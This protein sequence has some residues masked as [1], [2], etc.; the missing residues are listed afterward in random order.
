MSQS[1][2]KMPAGTNHTEL[3]C[4]GNYSEVERDFLFWVDGVALC[5]VSIPGLLLNVI[6]IITILTHKSMHNIFNYLLINLFIFDSTYILVTMLNQSFMKQFEIV[7]KLY[8]L[9]YPY[10]MHPLKHI[11][12]TASVFMTTT[13]AYERY[14][15]IVNPIE[16]RITMESKTARRL[17]LLMYILLVVLCS[18]L[19][20]V[21]KFMEAE[22]KWDEFNRYIIYLFLHFYKF[23]D[24]YIFVLFILLFTFLFYP[25]FYYFQME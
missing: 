8:I 25:S 15:A 11:S 23:L 19:F 20:N 7:P 14:L 5:S 21:P 6:A 16:H 9:I 13:I 2:M 24:Y 17:K 4:P 12:F 10:L 18:I 3:E 22:I 1:D